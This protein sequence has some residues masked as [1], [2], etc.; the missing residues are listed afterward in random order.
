MALETTNLQF[1]YHAEKAFKF[2]DIKLASA[3]AALIIGP[4]GSGKTTLLNLIAGLQKAS[5]G[6]VKLGDQFL[7]NLEGRSLERF[8]AKHLG[9]IFQKSLFLP[10]LTMMD[11]MKMIYAIQNR[12]ADKSEIDLL[13]SELNI[14]HILH[15]KAA[16]CSIGEQQRAAIARALLQKPS[17]ILA[18][19]PTAALDDTNAEKVGEL[20]LQMS[21]SQKTAL[22]VVTHDARL[23]KLISKS[24]QL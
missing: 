12:Q 21:Q 16:S 14:L 1:S 3:D 10:Y 18:D 5:A 24:Y 4:S 22:L 23:K 20:L 15:K 7:H 6:E 9:L 2:P 8:R 17:L 13:F 19:E 11:N